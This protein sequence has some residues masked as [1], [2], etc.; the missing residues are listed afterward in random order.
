MGFKP[1]DSLGKQD[2][3]TPKFS[4]GGF[5]KASFSPSIGTS[6]TSSSS[7]PIIESETKEDIRPKGTNEPIKFQ[8]RTGKEYQPFCVPL[9]ASTLADF[10]FVPVKR[11]Y[12]FRNTSKS[13]HSSSI[14]LL[15]FNLFLFPNSS[16]PNRFDP[17][18]IPL[19]FPLPH[20]F[21]DNFEKGLRDFEIMST[22]TRR[23][24]SSKRGGR[25]RH[26]V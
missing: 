20:S 12:R 8:I 5:A 6:S 7:I 25:E 16:I 23:I 24:G 26:V 1:G 18:P 14:H 2:Q 3:P 17:S 13:S 11:T 9:H 4:S 15:L 10:S 22:Y 21:D 19:Y